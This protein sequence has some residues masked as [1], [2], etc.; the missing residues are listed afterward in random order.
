MLCFCVS[1]E[2][3]AAFEAAVSAWKMMPER[4]I[5]IIDTRSLSMGQ[6]FMVLAAAEAAET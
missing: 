5:H 3:S 1:S 6:G 4:D 2:I